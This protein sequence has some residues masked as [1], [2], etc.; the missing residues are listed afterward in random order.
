MGK[1]T[2]AVKRTVQR[3]AR[4]RNG[5]KTLLMVGMPKSLRSCRVIPVPDFVL[6][7]LKTLFK[8]KADSGFVFGS[9]IAPAEPRT[10]Q[11]RFKR[12]TDRLG[13]AD[14]HFHTLRHSFATRL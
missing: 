9:S 10:I 8:S 6:K 7:Q 11:R 5:K 2:I 14:A 13:I 12:L 4:S 1:K 3:V